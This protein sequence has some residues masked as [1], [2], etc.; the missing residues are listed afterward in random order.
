M[1]ETCGRLERVHGTAGERSHGHPGRQILTDCSSGSDAPHWSTLFQ[2]A[3]HLFLSVRGGC[4][5]EAWSRAHSRTRVLVHS[6]PQDPDLE[7]D[8]SPIFCRGTLRTVTAD[9]VIL[10]AVA[11]L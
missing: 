10:D 4:T 11:D 6:R 9:H 3:Q 1:T 5:P 8:P 7:L 2:L